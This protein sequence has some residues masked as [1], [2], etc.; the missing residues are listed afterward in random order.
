MLLQLLKLS[1]WGVSKCDSMPKP[2][3][4]QRQGRFFSCGLYPYL[5]CWNKKFL[6]PNGASP[7]QGAMS[8]NWISCSYKCWAWPEMQYI[9]ST[10][11]KCQAS[12]GTPDLFPCSLI[13]RYKVRLPNP[14]QSC[15]V[16]A[17]LLLTLHNLLLP[18][19]PPQGMLHCLW[20]TVLPQSTDC[21][22]L[23]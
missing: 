14:K 15:P 3:S 13:F 2:A 10:H 5:W 7:A 9:Q 1:N 19:I 12:S 11:P 6:G 21:F 18:Q 22:S 20:G 17:L 23:E 8:A 4:K 16:S